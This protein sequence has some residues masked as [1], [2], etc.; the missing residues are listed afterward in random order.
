MPSPSAS[1][2]T[3]SP[4]LT[5]LVTNANGYAL[6][7]GVDAA[8]EL[9]E[10]PT[11]MKLPAAS[12]AARTGGWGPSDGYGR[13]SATSMAGVAV[14]LPAVSDLARRL[15]VSSPDGAVT[16]VMYETSTSSPRRYVA[17]G[18]VTLVATRSLVP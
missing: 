3:R 18:D 12:T 14:V 8:A 4:T 6:T 17:D 2:H 9:L 15:S 16:G 11:T 5:G 7:D 1:R 10:P 13:R